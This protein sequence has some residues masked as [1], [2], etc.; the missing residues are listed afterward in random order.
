MK[1]IVTAVGGMSEATLA[2]ARFVRFARH[3][4]PSA[5]LVFDLTVQ[6]ESRGPR[7]LL[8]PMQLPSD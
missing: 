1:K 3:W 5:A 8:V 7:W 2:L 6:N 4:P